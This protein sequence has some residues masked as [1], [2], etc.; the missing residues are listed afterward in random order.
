MC[1][2]VIRVPALAKAEQHCYRACYA[3]CVALVATSRPETCHMLSVSQKHCN[4]H[5]QKRLTVI[6][7]TAFA[8]VFPKQRLRL[9]GSYLYL[10]ELDLRFRNLRCQPIESLF[11]VEV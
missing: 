3:A 5:T 4:E 10:I 9:R 8:L 1:I 11:V 6:L 7:V 2:T